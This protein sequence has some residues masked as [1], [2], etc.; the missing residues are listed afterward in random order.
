MRSMV[1]E[2]VRNSSAGLAD[3]RRQPSPTLADARP[4]QD[5]GELKCLTL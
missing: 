5:I 1:E 3:T 4:E 2:V